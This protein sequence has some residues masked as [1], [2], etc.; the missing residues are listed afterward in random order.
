M[1]H[2]T[3]TTTS[4]EGRA[5]PTAIPYITAW[6]SEQDNTEFALVVRDNRLAYHNETAADRDTRGALWVRH[7]GRAG[8][9]RPRFGHVHPLRQRE[10]MTGLRCQVCAGEAS[11]TRAGLLFLVAPYPA[12]QRWTGWPDDLHTTHPPLCVPC[13]RLSAEQCH[14]LGRGFV[15]LRARKVVNAGVFGSVYKPYGSG[16]VLARAAAETLYAAPAS[17]WMLASQ[18]MVELRRCTVVDLNAQ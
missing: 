7:S 12:D 6:T 3:Q 11:R 9:G 17:R 8:L 10:V 1:S 15:A 13:A 18:L 2:T 14:F 4:S 5:R 16:A